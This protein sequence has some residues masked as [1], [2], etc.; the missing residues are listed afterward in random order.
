MALVKHVHTVGDSVESA[1]ITDGT[2]VAADL[3]AG[4]MVAV[5]ALTDGG[6]RLQASG[7]FGQNVAGAAVLPTLTT[8]K[9]VLFQA[10]AGAGEY[11]YICVGDPVADSDDW[12]V[13]LMNNGSVRLAISNLNELYV[14]TSAAAG[15]EIHYGY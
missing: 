9:S 4:A 13:R 11:V 15:A 3:A 14:Y 7:H 2:I 8:N 5:P 1:E 10:V 12:A 6:N